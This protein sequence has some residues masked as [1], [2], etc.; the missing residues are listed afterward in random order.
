MPT[1][2]RTRRIAAIHIAVAGAL[3]AAP[4][5]EAQQVSGAASVT[6]ASSPISLQEVVVTSRRVE[7]NLQS[8]PLALSAFR[9]EGIEARSIANIG[10]AAEFT[11]N[12]LSNPGPTGGNDGFFFIR[13]VGQTDLNAATDPG[14]ATYV[15]GVYLGRVIG[16][17]L[18]TLDIARIEVLRG[19]QGTFFGRN[20]VG[21]AVSVTTADPSGQFQASA[22]ID[23]GSR[24]LKRGQFSL[25]VPVTDQLG[26]LISGLYKGQ[27]GWVS[28]PGTDL[29]YNDTISRDL[30]IKA[31]YSASDAFSATLT[32]E[33]ERLT[34]TSEANS[35]IAFN[36]NFKVIPTLPGVTP[37]GVPINP[38]VG[39][40]LVGAGSAG[41]FNLDSDMNPRLDLKVWGASL[42]L[43]GKLAGVD[44]KS[45]TAYRSMQHLSQG[46]FDGGPYSVYDQAFVTRQ[47]QISEELQ[48]SGKAASL[49]WL[50]GLFFYK[51]DAFHDNQIDL[52][53]NNGC[54]FFPVPGTPFCPLPLYQTPGLSR[55]IQNNQQIDLND[56]SYAAYANGTWHFT[57]Q[58]S[59]TAGLRFTNERKIQDYNF[60]VDNTAGV[61][62]FFNLGPF[63]AYPP[64]QITYTFSP[65]NHNPF[66]SGAPTSYEK[67]W[68][69]VTPSASF[70]W[71]VD[72]NTLFYL[73]YARGF[74]SGGFNGRP[75][76]GPNG[77][78]GTVAPYD[79]ETNDTIELGMKS[80][81]F[82]HRMRLNVATFWSNYKGI[83]L[84]AI[85]A[86]TGF[87]NTLNAARA[88]ITGLEAELTARPIG[89]LELQA[90]LGWMHNEYKELSQGA[91]LSG[92]E[93]GNKL[94]LTPD[95]NASLGVSYRWN[96]PTGG[97]TL[98]GDWSYRSQI[99][100]QADNLPNARQ[101]G[102][103]LVNARLTYEQD[104]PLLISLYGLN[105]A[106][107]IYITNAQD[108]T[109]QL[110]VAFASVGAP[111]EWGI[112]LAYRIGTHR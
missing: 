61:L 86:T 87:F 9:P 34:G 55:A 2:Y 50:A 71:Q 32:L 67:S 27:N 22:R 26:V 79:P 100:F 31:K 82:E 16:A 1:S 103:G 6:E 90:G 88:R 7:E 112:E 25:D 94:P 74:K 49:D 77:N 11:P 38:F 104:G 59:L 68:S 40:Y 39:N 97:V 28:K 12:F 73:S 10:Q 36:P 64:G 24:N 58:W 101:G 111:R 3:S 66:T 8:T 44:L 19:P 57:S 72:P 51:E 37:L 83:Q 62:S 54:F 41:M 99:F 42:T 14:V 5:L 18:D 92:I 20:T 81:W 69:E 23:A 30:R 21:G 84:L 52:G 56:R 75:A 109:P 29:T 95:A 96:V 80:E 13:G 15:D 43:D 53:G 35:L 110:G 33:R 93:Y 48:A 4:A 91:Q 45:I 89:A 105:L 47:H 65:N 102:Y 46:D 106:D 76:P 107:K 60:F 17:S 78:F 70:N 85:D 108:V 98:R 63:P